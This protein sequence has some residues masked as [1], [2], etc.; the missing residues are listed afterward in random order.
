MSEHHFGL[1]RGRV[2]KEDYRRIDQIAAKHGATF[3]NPNL[4]GDG[5]RYWFSC[6]N[7]GQPFDGDT[8]RAVL[9][10]VEAAGIKLPER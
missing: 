2:S 1:G 5:W 3:T 7:R 10:E 6:P 4:P 9:G 8:A